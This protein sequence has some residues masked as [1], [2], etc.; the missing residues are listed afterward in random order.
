MKTFSSIATLFFICFVLAGCGSQPAAGPAAKP[1]AAPPVPT[2]EG[3]W[4]VVSLEADGKPVPA[5]QHKNLHLVFTKTLMA[6]IGE[7]QGE[8]GTY[9]FDSSKTPA[10]IDLRMNS[11]TAHGIYEL[12][13]DSLKLSI[14]RGM[15]PRPT[16][17]ASPGAKETTSFVLRRAAAAPAA[18]ASIEGTWYVASMEAGGKADRPESPEEMRIVLTKTMFTMPGNA[19][20]TASYTVDS[21]K[22]PAEIDLTLG[23][24]NGSTDKVLGIYELNGNSLKLSMGNPKEPRPIEFT[25]KPGQKHTTF[26][27]ERGAPLPDAKK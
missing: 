15:N 8:L 3:A 24:P 18:T 2:L 26:V 22:K 16:E 19:G 20:G 17:F 21:Q 23:T 11:M 5:E 25:T 13:G 10:E 9:T 4:E 12:D 1:P 6:T 7:N 14:T 27:L